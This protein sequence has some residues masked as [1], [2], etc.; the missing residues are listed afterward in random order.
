MITKK[1][2]NEF[3]MLNDRKI[4]DAKAKRIQLDESLK[5][6]TEDSYSIDLSK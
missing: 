2:L 1:D 6:C 3:K 5:E 4:E